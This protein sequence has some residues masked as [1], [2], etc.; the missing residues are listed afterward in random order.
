MAIYQNIKIEL[1]TDKDCP[2]VM[3]AR[4][5]LKKA[6]KQLNWNLRGKSIKSALLQYLHTC[7]GWV[8]LQY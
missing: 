2:N 7:M 4:G 6:L 5:Q 3:S 1:L 8:R